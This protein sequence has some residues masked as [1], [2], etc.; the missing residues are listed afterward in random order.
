MIAQLCAHIEDWLERAD[1]LGSREP[2]QQ[3]S[4]DKKILRHK[5]EL[6]V[7]TNL[8]IRINIEPRVAIY[9]VLSV[10]ETHFT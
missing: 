8:T 10:V 1:S 5:V 6:F 9:L 7:R 3:D 2:G 4:K